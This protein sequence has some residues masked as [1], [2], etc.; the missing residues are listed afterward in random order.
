MN[1]EWARKELILERV[2]SLIK[3]FHSSSSEA[4]D[5]YFSQTVIKL[6]TKKRTQS[7]TESRTRKRA[8]RQDVAV[9]RN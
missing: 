8:N 4:C 2:K 6:H 9:S 1:V 3:L 5:M 7:S